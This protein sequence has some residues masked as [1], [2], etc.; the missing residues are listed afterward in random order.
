MQKLSLS[1]NG[2]SPPTRRDSLN[3]V[4]RHFKKPA[5]PETKEA[6]DLNEYT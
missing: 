3:S 2:D 6:A 5:T 4:R 1:L